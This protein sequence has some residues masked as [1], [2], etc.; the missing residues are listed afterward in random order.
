MQSVVLSVIAAAMRIVPA[1]DSARGG[2]QSQVMPR[3]LLPRSPTC[4]ASCLPS[5]LKELPRA[6]EFI[7]GLA[8]GGYLEHLDPVSHGDAYLTV[9][10]GNGAMSR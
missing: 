1:V 6:A 9:I 7:S 3:L 5:S 4:A 2:W 10:L 8:Q